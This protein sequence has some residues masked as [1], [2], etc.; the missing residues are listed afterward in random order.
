MLRRTISRGVRTA[1]RVAGN[2]AEASRAL[3]RDTSRSYDDLVVKNASLKARNRKLIRLRDAY[4]A[5]V[6]RLEEELKDSRAKLEIERRRVQ[7]Q[8]RQITKFRYA[9]RSLRAGLLGVR[10]AELGRP[11]NQAPE[12]DVRKEYEEQAIVEHRLANF[13]RALADGSGLDGAVAEIVRRS[14]GKRGTAVARQIVQWLYDQAETRIAGL[15]GTGLMA[16]R[17]GLER[18][19]WERL[20]QLPTDVWLRYAP[21]EYI[22]LSGRF[23][24][25]ACKRAAVAAL[26]YPQAIPLQNWLD[27]TRRSMGLGLSDVVPA[28][29][30]RYISLAESE[31]ESSSLTEKQREGREADL[32]W[33]K[34]WAPRVASGPAQPVESNPGTIPFAVLGYDQPD[35]RRTSTNIGD[36]VQ[37]VASLAHLVRHANARFVENELGKFANRLA[38]R[39]PEDLR[40]LGSRANVELHQIDRDAASYSP[41]P[42]GTWMLAFGWFGHQIGG[43][44]HDLPFPEHV[45]PLYISFH[46]NK[47]TLLS[48]EMIEHLRLHA[49]IGCRDWSTVDLLLGLGIPAFFSGCMT[50]TVRYV[51]N[52][53]TGREID[54]PTLWVDVLAADGQETIRNERREV[55]LRSLVENLEEAVDTLDTYAEQAGRVVTKRLHAYLPARSLGCPVEFVPRNVSDVRFNGLAPLSDEEVY[56]MG[57][58]IAA[59]LEPAMSRILAGSSEAEVR[60][61][62]SDSTADLVEAARSRHRK[63]VELPSHLDVRSV[64]TTI[65]SR[66]VVFEPFVERSSAG[67][68]DVVMALDKNLKNEFEVVLDALV[69]N[70]SRAIRLH[71]L[72]REHTNADFERV[73]R[74]F[75][76]V[77]FNW[78]SCD[79]VD[80]GDI[81]AM[82]P[83]ITVSTMDRLLIP[84]LLRDILRVVYLDID[85]LPLGDVAELFDTDL[86]GMPLA[87]RDSEASSLTSGYTSIFA[88]ATS[89]ELRAGMGAELIRRGTAQH[90]FDWTGFNAGV[91][92]LDLERMRADAFCE[93][94]IP[95]AF[96]FGMHDQ[97]ILNVYVGANR[98]PLDPSWNARP[99]QENID[100]PR[101]VHWAGQQKPWNSGYVPYRD[102]WDRQVQR[103]AARVAGVESSRGD[104]ACVSE[105][106]PLGQATPLQ[107]MV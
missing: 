3:T 24:P 80:Y 98:V 22:M 99:T 62:W 12:N 30:N 14:G 26:E 43:V 94:Y 76:T 40:V 60:R 89:P 69:E 51:A 59:I 68:V 21:S 16:V 9:Y 70:S 1:R 67:V 90:P 5:E 38:E 104:A 46:I 85:I 54:G 48:Q 56:R 61:A 101:I 77:A 81:H 10:P 92:V 57:E 29:A 44:R 6:N 33:I 25:E 93:T 106:T 78:Y 75:P 34:R 58:T 102:L 35:R 105:S 18:F 49:P 42:A 36:Y 37:T 27:L 39:V 4:R 66:C 28:L 64:V 96:N 2:V 83:H 82:I 84:E 87:A 17:M 100:R 79:G 95:Y 50:T 88:P 7:R 63:T 15:L 73:A 20:S 23:D 32:A 19:A 13:A 74:L 11:E 103:L 53:R 72:C 31:L 45:R 41:V 107:Q 52:R 91:L 55:A 71:V 8:R 86:R 47:R 97:H 65:R